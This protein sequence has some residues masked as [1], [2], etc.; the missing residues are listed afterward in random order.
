MKIPIFLHRIFYSDE[1]ID[2]DDER[3]TRKATN[4]NHLPDTRE[5]IAIDISLLKKQYIKLRER[6]RQAN[7]SNVPKQIKQPQTTST[8]TT[9]ATNNAKS[10]NINQY[11]IGRN[12]IVSNKGKRIGP[13]VGAIPPARVAVPLSATNKYRDKRLR[14]ATIATVDNA[15]TSALL[16][17]RTDDNS[18]VPRK[19]S[20]LVRKRSESSS[21]SEDSEKDSDDEVN[22][23]VR[24]DSSSSD[25]SLCDEE[26]SMEAS[27]MKS[28]APSSAS[29]DSERQSFVR[30]EDPEIDALKFLSKKPSE[31][32]ESHLSIDSDNGN[33]DIGNQATEVQSTKD[34]KR[35]LNLLHLPNRSM[36][37]STS[38]LSPIADISNYLGSSSISPLKTPTSYLLNSYPM[39][40]L[41][42]KTVDDVIDVAE[43]K[44]PTKQLKEFQVSDEGVTNAY[45]ER[46]NHVTSVDPEPPSLLFDDVILNAPSGSK[47]ME[48][49]SVRND[50]TS[51]L[52]D[53]DN[54]YSDPIPSPTAMTRKNNDLILKIIEE[55]SRILDRIMMKN[56]QS[57]IISSSN[58]N[59]DKGRKE[60]DIQLHQSP[61]P[62][63][64]STTAAEKVNEEIRSP[65]KAVTYPNIIISS[66]SSDKALEMNETI[67]ETPT[68]DECISLDKFAGATES[69]EQIFKYGDL[70]ECIS[71]YLTNSIE[72]TGN[73]SENTIKQSEPIDISLKSTDSKP[74]D[75]ETPSTLALLVT[76]HDNPDDLKNLLKQSFYEYSKSPSESLP[77][78]SKLEND[79]ETLLKMSAELL[80]DE[81]PVNV[82]TPEPFS[83]D[84]LMPSVEYQSIDMTTST[85]S[86]E[87]SEALQSG[88]N[89]V[90]FDADALQIEMESVAGDISATISSIKNTIKSIDS[91]CQED[92]RRS[93]E[94]TDKTLDDI[95][96]VVE[97]LDE[98]RASRS[99]SRDR[100]TDTSPYRPLTTSSQH[101]ARTKPTIDTHSTNVESPRYLASLR[102]SRD[103]SRIT[104]I[105]RRNDD[106]FSEYESRA[107]RNKSPLAEEYR[108]DEDP[109]PLKVDVET[110]YRSIEIENSST[111]PYKMGGKLELRHTTVTS[112]F[113]DRFLS[114]KFEA[115][116]RM[117]RSPSSPIINKAYLNTL[118]P[119][120][121]TSYRSDHH[122]RSSKSNETSPESLASSV[123]SKSRPKST[124]VQ[125]PQFPMSAISRETCTRSCDNILPDLNVKT[126]EVEATSP[127]YTTSTASSRTTDESIDR[128]LKRHSTGVH[129][130]PTSALSTKPKKPSE[131]G[132][133]LGMY[134]PS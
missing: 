11:L 97:K 119:T 24:L 8:S 39:C 96:K 126:S 27:S 107:R 124:Y 91:L 50:S 34:D 58:T 25:T 18:N 14:N 95:I 133:K 61:P 3:A 94:R 72:T 19:S 73:S 79:L 87:S 70:S 41:N 1:D 17:L 76:D 85:Q 84:P 82:S 128:I 92:D 47:S 103:R 77:I 118:K 125:L 99:Q 38:Q 132:I 80:R 6:Q 131:L 48:L 120:P 15:S 43:A 22:C 122:N 113:Y 29:D 52:S 44:K 54:K 31:E 127:K 111:S 10:S 89:S 36:I 60:C 100:H 49:I 20:T 13:P 114:Q 53:S 106:D 28:R 63:T 42:T 9:T 16:K 66:D 69:D 67:G 5:R 104:S 62:P 129:Y 98:E 110:L 45:F 123:P 33:N 23:R 68:K 71:K 109:D 134:K 2:S 116:F 57:S 78:D 86:D 55:N 30:L 108:E 12:A 46:V 59:E 51:D 40:E 75:S 21:Y 102:V 105:S 115:R 88:R 90:Y 65:T 37:T 26:Y 83:V 4:R 121:S 35:D 56:T 74:M 32:N 93:R 112:T 7:I 101:E 81:F 64:E 130:Q 117:D